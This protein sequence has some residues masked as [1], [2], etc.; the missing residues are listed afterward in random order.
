MISLQDAHDKAISNEGGHII[1][2]SFSQVPTSGG[3]FNYVFLLFFHATL[4]LKLQF[5]TDCLL[6]LLFCPI[7]NNKAKSAE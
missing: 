3:S 5:K 7:K 4:Q 1:V 6:N 2:L